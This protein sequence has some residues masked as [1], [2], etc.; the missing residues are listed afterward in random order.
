MTFQTFELERWQ[1]DFEQTVDIN[2][3][4]SSV[5]GAG[6]GEVLTLEERER[7]FALELGYPEVNGTARLRHLVTRQYPSAATANVLVTVGGAEA[8]QIVCQTVLEPGDRVIVMEPGYRQVHGLA[9]GLG[10]DVAPF[11]LDPDHGWRPD[12]DRLEHEVKRGAQLIY[13]VNPNNP[14]GT[15]LTQRDMQVIVDLAARAGA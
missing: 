15:I 8:N 9:T 11:P 14:T 10:C 6:L 13:V 4:D 5:R 3:A 2:L 12:F 7:F 1:S